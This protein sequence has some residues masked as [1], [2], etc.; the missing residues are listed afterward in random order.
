MFKFFYSL[1]IVFQGDDDAYVCI[2]EGETVHIKPSH[3]MGRSH[4]VMDSGVG[5][6]ILGTST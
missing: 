6:K 2:R 3:L 1:A 4:P 5:V